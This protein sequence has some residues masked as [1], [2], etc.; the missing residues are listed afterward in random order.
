MIG[1]P[2]RQKD[3]ILI[4][5]NSCISGKRNKGKIT[6]FSPLPRWGTFTVHWLLMLY[7][8][9]LKHWH[10]SSPSLILV[11]P[12]K[13][14]TGIMKD[15]PLKGKIRFESTSGTWMCTSPQELM[16]CIW[17]SSGDWQMKLLSHSPSFEKWKG[18]Y[19]IHFQKGRKGRSRDLQYSQSQSPIF[20]KI[21]K[22]ILF[23]ITMLRHR[24]IK[25]V[26]GD[27][28]YGFTKSKLCLINLVVYDGVTAL[29]DKGR[30]TNIIYLD[31]CKTLDTTSSSPIWRDMDL[32]DGQW[33]KNWLYDCIRRVA[34]NGL[35]I[36]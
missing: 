24:E 25:E 4:K 35:K 15:R 3:K 17:R 7:P 31:L 10:H 33:I 16:R 19:N 6:F 30:G 20:F 27:S 11:T 32:T 18:K 22:H 12:T 34:V 1:H 36:K 5:L 29:V 13:A 9:L 2:H 21:M 26:I 23:L 28:Q 8:E 14:E